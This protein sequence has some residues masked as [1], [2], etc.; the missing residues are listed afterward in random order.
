MGRQ[1]EFD[2][3]KVLD[4]AVEVFW[5]KG[6]EG[7]SYDDLTRVTGVKRPGLYAA[8]GN[9]EEFFN[10]AV[11]RYAE[12]YMGYMTEALD[13]PTSRKMAEYVLRGA[14]DI[15]TRFP[16]HPGCLGI[17]GALASSK[18]ADPVREMLVGFRAGGAHSLRDRLERFKVEGNLPA[19]ADCTGLATYLMAVIHGMAVQAKSGLCR[20]ALDAVI[21][22]ALTG[23]PDPPAK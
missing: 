18:E 16:Q 17:N 9:K 6:Y 10:R 8:F 1:R 7:T 23:W 19:S 20:Q 15:A 2:V 4:A 21:E 14:A 5:E 13:E 11:V 12:Q 3:D 22:Q